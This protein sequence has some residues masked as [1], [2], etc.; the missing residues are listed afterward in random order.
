MPLTTFVKRLPR[1]TFRIDMW[2]LRRPRL[3]FRIFDMHLMRQLSMT[4]KF[5]THRYMI[6]PSTPGSWRI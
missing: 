2:S 4:N 3:R 6:V 1:F 5:Q